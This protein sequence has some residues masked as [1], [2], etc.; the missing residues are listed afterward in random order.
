EPLVAVL[1]DIAADADHAFDEILRRIDRI[2]END[3]VAA[4]RIAQRNDL[5]LDYRQPDAVNEFVDENEIAN[6]QRGAH[7]RRWD[8]ERLRQKRAQQEHDQQD[9]KECL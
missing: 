3:D 9:R 8:L 2:A 6:L 7:R 5:F 4:L 1:D